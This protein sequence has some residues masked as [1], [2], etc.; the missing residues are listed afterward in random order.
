MPIQIPLRIENSVTEKVAQL[1]QE[2]TK[3][4]AAILV[5]MRSGK[6]GLG[7]Y[8]KRVKVTGTAVCQCQRSNETVTHI[9]GDCF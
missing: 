4:E 6:I 3:P 8:L 5:Q 1:Y 9:L 7:A 2:L